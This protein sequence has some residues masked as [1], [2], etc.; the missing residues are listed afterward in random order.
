M[1]SFRSLHRPVVLMVF[2]IWDLFNALTQ[3]AACH[4]VVYCSLLSDFTG[5]NR[6]L[7]Y[8]RTTVQ[9]QYIDNVLPHQLYMF[10]WIYAH[11]EFEGSATIQTSWDGGQ[12]KTIECCKNTS[13]S[14]RRLNRLLVIGNSAM[15]EQ[16]QSLASKDGPTF[17]TWSNTWLY[18]G[19]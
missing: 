4:H 17:T 5:Q 18:E 13:F 11:S 7:E 3:M 12:Q 2:F 14:T 10:L 6:R 15:F 19:Y 9:R 16:A 8:K 1:P